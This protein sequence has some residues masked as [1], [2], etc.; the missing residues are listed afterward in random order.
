MSLGW[1]RHVGER[2]ILYNIKGNFKAYKISTRN[3]EK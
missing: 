3:E 2:E 1:Q